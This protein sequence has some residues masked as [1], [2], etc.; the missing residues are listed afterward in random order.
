MSLQKANVGG[1]SSRITGSISQTHL[2]RAPPLHAA[3]P[4]TS[5]LWGAH[6]EA[7]CQDPL[8]SLSLGSAKNVRPWE[9]ILKE[10][11]W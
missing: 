10:P 11:K 1:G 9:M 2:A 5:I 3:P 6:W 8:K 4:K 7:V